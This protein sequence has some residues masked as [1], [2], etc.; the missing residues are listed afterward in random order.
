MTTDSSLDYFTRAL[1]GTMA[2]AVVGFA[3]NALVFI[4]MARFLNPANF[5]NLKVAASTMLVASVAVG[6]GGSRAAGRF[7]PRRIKGSSAAT[8]YI[9]FYVRTIVSLSLLLAGGLWIVVLLLPGD[10]PEDIHGHHPVSFVVLLVPVWAG[11]DLLS[12]VYMVTRR[13]ILAAL[14]TR[15]VFPIV[16]LGFIWWAH[17]TGIHLSDVMFVLV[18][19]GAGL[20]TLLVFAAILWGLEAKDGPE[21]EDA[22]NSTGET[23]TGPRDWMALSLPMVGAGLVVILV[24]EVPLFALAFAGDEAEIGLYGAAIT[25]TQIF[26]IVI[27]CQR[28]IYGPAMGKLLAEGIETTRVLHAHA[29]RQ[30]VLYVVP[31]LAMVVLGAEQLLLLFGPGFSEA[32]VVVWILAVGY[33]VPAVTALSAR[34]LD[35]AGHARL[36][37]TTE[38]AAA[39]AMV[40]GSVVMVPAFGMLG[41]ASVFAAVLSTRSLYLA[42]M[43]SRRL[44]L[45]LIAYGS[46]IERGSKPPHER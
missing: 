29:Q 28:Q 5:G 14:P 27:T 35:Y 11:L 42:A 8:G 20:A 40:L 6:L 26:L 1:P 24:A 30:A 22:E 15:F 41:A 16:G 39:A 37:L 23:Q 31:M 45:P 46:C 18:L 36:V 17:A 44:G 25:L 4:T 7:L 38:I 33:A 13:P 3:L 12:Q 43:A 19:S 21:D 32:R 34:W 10:L 9:G 2:I